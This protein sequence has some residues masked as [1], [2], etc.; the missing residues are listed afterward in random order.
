MKI[1]LLDRL[2]LLYKNKALSKQRFKTFRGQLLAGDIEGCIKGLLR[3]K[4]INKRWIIENLK[5][6]YE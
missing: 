2:Q 3:L 1:R 6:D 4:V 5:H